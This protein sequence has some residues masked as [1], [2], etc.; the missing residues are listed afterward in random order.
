MPKGSYRLELHL[1]FWLFICS[2]PLMPQ[3]GSEAV[4]MMKNKKEERR[5]KKEKEKEK[6]KKKRRRSVSFTGG[7]NRSIDLREVTDKLSHIRPVP[8]PS[9]EPGP[10]WTIRELG[11]HL[12]CIYYWK[13]WFQSSCHHVAITM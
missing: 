1:L 9:T 5:R 10:Q 7:G 4:M 12:G 11:K 2:G 13:L 6:E 8:S 3:P